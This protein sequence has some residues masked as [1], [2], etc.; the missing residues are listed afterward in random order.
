[1]ITLRAPWDDDPVLEH[2]RLLQAMELAFGY[3]RAHGGI[4]LT[5]TRAFNR[6]FA[7]WLAERSPWPQYRADALLRVNK[8]LNEWDVAPAMVVHDLM[9]VGN[10]D[11][12]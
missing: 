9:V 11:S 1:M 4:G 6:K 8:V 12:N 10:D 2:S 7:H 3:A 5:Q